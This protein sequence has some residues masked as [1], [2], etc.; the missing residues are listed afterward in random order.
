MAEINQF[1]LLAEYNLLMNQRQYAAAANLSKT[2]LCEDKGAFFKS[3]LGTLNHVMV[4]DIVWLKRFAGHPSSRESLS[5]ICELEKPRSLDATLFIDFGELK[6]ER[7][8]IDRIIVNWIKQ[9]S[10]SD[11]NECI[12]YSSMAGK[13]F[14]KPFV[15]L[16]N[17]LFLHQVHH[18]G[19]VTTLLSQFGVDFGETDLIE[20]INECSA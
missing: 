1:I 16:I 9:L 8:I 5:Y 3:V 20:I 14:S 2:D 13:S 18:R 10:D 12:S 7:E 17:H 6:A 11:V 15:S 4:G 19:Q